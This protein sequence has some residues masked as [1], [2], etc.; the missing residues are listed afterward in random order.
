MYIIFQISTVKKKSQNS[1]NQ[2]FSYYFC[3][4]IEG[5]ASR[6]VPVTN[7]FWSGSCS[8]QKHTYGFRICY[9][10]GKHWRPVI[11]FGGSESSGA[12]GGFSF[13]G[14]QQLQPAA[15]GFTFGLAAGQPAA[16]SATPA[17]VSPL[18]QLLLI[19]LTF[20]VFVF[21]GFRC[22]SL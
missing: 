15:S 16:A 11:Q 3:L 1:R 19:Y 6:S 22:N 12:G 8:P 18:Q 17:Q 21:A 20:S 10:V 14:S 7:V 4:V 13:G 9:T 5:S 2:A